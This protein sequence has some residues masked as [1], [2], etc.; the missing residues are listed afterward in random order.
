MQRSGKIIVEYEFITHQDYAV[1]E[2]KSLYVKTLNSS[3]DG[4][5]NQENVLKTNSYI[6][7]LFFENI[8]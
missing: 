1:S 2:I 3:W 7:K 8:S 6:V 4:Y 5:K